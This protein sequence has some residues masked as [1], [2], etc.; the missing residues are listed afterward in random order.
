MAP[1]QTGY[2]DVLLEQQKS[3]QK[4]RCPIGRFLATHEDEVVREGI[5]EALN[6]P[7]IYATTIA[8]V[9]TKAGIAVGEKAVRAHRTRACSC[10][11]R[12]N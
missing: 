1:S 6:T 7:S 9:I 8:K 2:L 10:S 5:R 4:I 3:D 12:G 11:R